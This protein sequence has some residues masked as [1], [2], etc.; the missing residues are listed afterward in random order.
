M[1]EL[2]PA[3]SPVE[4]LREQ[5]ELVRQLVATNHL[6]FAGSWEDFAED[7]RR[8]KAGRPYLFKQPFDIDET[9]VW[10][11]RLQDYERVR[12]EPLAEALAVE[13]NL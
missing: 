1:H 8:R 5:G 2:D 10:I 11:H 6:L 12:R 7:V 3:K 13:D 4:I 9:L